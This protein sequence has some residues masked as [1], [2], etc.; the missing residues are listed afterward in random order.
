MAA[1]W[2]VI[3]LAL[4]QL[5][6]LLLTTLAGRESNG[7]AR[8]VSG[9]GVMRETHTHTHTEQPV[10]FPVSF[11]LVCLCVCVFHCLLSFCFVRED[12]ECLPVWL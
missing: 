10:C 2:L 3:T 11:S 7:A 4:S 9:K 6:M 8:H 5:I 12:F 1:N